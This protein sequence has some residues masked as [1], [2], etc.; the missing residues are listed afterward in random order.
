MIARTRDLPRPSS[1][2]Q[3][4][5]SSAGAPQREHAQL[6]SVFLRLV[7]SRPC[8]R[9]PHDR[10]DRPGGPLSGFLCAQ[11]A[12]GQ[13]VVV[14]VPRCPTQ[15]PSGSPTGGRSASLRHPAPSRVARFHRRRHQGDV[16]VARLRVRLA[17]GE[18]SRPRHRRRILLPA[19]AR[20][21]HAM[22]A[23]HRASYRRRHVCRFAV[24][25][26]LGRGLHDVA[27]LP[28]VTKAV[29]E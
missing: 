25:R 16:C 27:R 26:P 5:E 9:P 7:D 1:L 12:G 18:P 19:D 6:E 4:P 13:P 20:C 22:H 8:C 23:G 2:L 14:A 11:L 10:G 28:D 21:R 3:V 15:P 24:S 17:S 29:R